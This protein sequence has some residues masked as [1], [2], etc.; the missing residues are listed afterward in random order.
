MEKVR[1]ERLLLFRGSDVATDALKQ[2]VCTSAEHLIHF[3]SSKVTLFL[4][5]LSEGCRLPAE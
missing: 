5:S 3:S 2:I 1:E 4:K